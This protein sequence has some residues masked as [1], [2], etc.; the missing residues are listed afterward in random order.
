MYIEQLSRGWGCSDEHSDREAMIKAGGLEALERWLRSGPAIGVDVYGQAVFGVQIISSFG[1]EEHR[2]AVR[3][4]GA[5]EAVISWLA[6][7]RLEGTQHDYPRE[8]SDFLLSDAAKLPSGREAVRKI[9]DGTSGEVAAALDATERLNSVVVGGGGL[10]VATEEGAP[11]ALIRLLGE[12]EKKAAHRNALNVLFTIARQY[13][14][15]VA[16]AASEC[17]QRVGT[18]ITTKST[19]EIIIPNKAFPM[20][21]WCGDAPRVLSA[22]AGVSKKARATIAATVQRI[23]EDEDAEVCGWLRTLAAA[24]WSRLRGHG[25][26]WPARWLLPD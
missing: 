15:E 10:D 12:K 18:A 4:S 5:C 8:R 13:P 25:C 20:L 24:P 26:S 3:T 16:P 19:A 23:F 9:V 22:I 11:A 7:G 2:E 17:T 21:T 14:N 1:S 6:R